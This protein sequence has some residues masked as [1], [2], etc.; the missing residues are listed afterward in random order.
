MPRS[1]QIPTPT[2]IEKLIKKYTK[3]FRI[4]ENIEYYSR[5]DYIKAEKQFVKHCIKHGG[6]SYSRG[7][8]QVK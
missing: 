4:R 2:G 3:Q 7:A 5:E 8:S 6:V 1:K